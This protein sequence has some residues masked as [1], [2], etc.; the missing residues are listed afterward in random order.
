[1]EVMDSNK[2]LFTVPQESHYQ[3]IISQGPWNVRGSL[4]LLQPWSPNLAIEEL[5]LHFSA[6]WIQVHKLPLQFMTTKNAIKIGKGIGKILELDN[7][8]SFGLICH[9]FIRFRIKINT[10]K[11]LAPGFYMSC[12]GEEPHWIAF[13]YERLDEY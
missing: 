4:L 3:S 9:Q 6:L 8:N 13:K 10:S 12:T 11:P 2:Y 1:M 7:N 5:K